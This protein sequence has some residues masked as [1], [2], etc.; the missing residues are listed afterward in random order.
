MTGK[1]PLT[2]TAEQRDGLLR[3]SGSPDRAEADRARAILLS[4]AGWTSAAIDRRGLRSARGHGSR[5][6]F[7]LHARRLDGH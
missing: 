6:A 1:S 7:G 4:L 3:L 5:L 2:V